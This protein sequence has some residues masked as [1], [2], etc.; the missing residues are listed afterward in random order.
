[1]GDIGIIGDTGKLCSECGKRWWPNPNWFW[2]PGHIPSDRCPNC[3][4]QL[5]ALALDA[6][7]LGSEAVTLGAPIAA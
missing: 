3:R 4:K 2:D 7:E 6:A 5:G 1:M